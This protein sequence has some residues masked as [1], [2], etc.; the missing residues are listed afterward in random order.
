M[1]TDL[2][3]FTDDCKISIDVESPYKWC[4]ER[5]MLYTLGLEL[6]KNNEEI[7]QGEVFRLV[8]GM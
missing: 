3:D 8:F 4:A 5:P 7:V 1:T 6:I 2:D